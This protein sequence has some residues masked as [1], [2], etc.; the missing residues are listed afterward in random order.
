MCKGQNIGIKASYVF[1][2]WEGLIYQSDMQTEIIKNFSFGIYGHAPLNP[3]IAFEPGIFITPKGARMMNGPF[4]VPTTNKSLYID[5]PILVKMYIGGAGF[6]I[7]AGPQVSYLLSNKMVLD[8]GTETDTSDQLTR[9]DFAIDFG[10]AYDFKFGLTL[11]TSFDLGIYNY[12]INDYY[13]WT[14]ASN[15]VIRVSM[16]Y[17][18]N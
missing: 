17:S 16:G 5:V 18:F 15:R 4:Q 12:L 6:H 9:W 14:S 8:D 13:D 2:N 7:D 10:L 3:I 1:T 11:G